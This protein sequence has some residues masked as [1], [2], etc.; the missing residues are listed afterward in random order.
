MV[1]GCTAAATARSRS[2][3]AVAISSR[4]SL[5]I[6]AFT[7]GPCSYKLHGDFPCR[8]TAG[9][10]D[11]PWLRDSILNP[12]PSRYALLKSGS[13]SLRSSVL[14]TGQMGVLRGPE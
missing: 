2:R 12:R 9:A 6:I 7:L 8:D 4:G 1:I 5:R 3:G 11:S 13:F 10:L 14:L